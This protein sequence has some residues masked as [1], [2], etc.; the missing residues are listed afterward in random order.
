MILPLV[1]HVDAP[2]AAVSQMS[3][4][5]TRTTTGDLSLRYV[6]KGDIAQILLAEPAP[7]ER[8][9]QLWRH[10]CFEIFI[11]MP[12]EAGYHEY[13][14]APSS[15]WAA[16]GFDDRRL[17]MHNLEIGHPPVI[18]AQRTAS[19][20]ILTASLASLDLLRDA[21]WQIGLSVIIEE[22]SGGL[23]FWA[24]AHPKGAADFHHEDCFALT[25]SPPE[26]CP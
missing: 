10:S 12:G 22:S 13:N 14:F 16:Y 23:S 20:F 17:G 9:H 18:E 6:V 15:H 4:E 11:R 1:R 26:P 5:I 2:F 19:E 24:L 3:V 8:S 7:P 25:L 21:S